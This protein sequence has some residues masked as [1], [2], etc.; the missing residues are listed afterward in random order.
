M[1]DRLWP[2]RI[3]MLLLGVAALIFLQRNPQL[4][5]LFSIWLL[6]VALRFCPA[7]LVRSELVAWGLAA[8]GIASYGVVLDRFGGLAN[9]VVAVSFANVVLTAMHSKRGA[10]RGAEIFAAL[11]GFSYSLYLLHAPMLHFVLTLGR[12]DADPRIGLPPS[13]WHAAV[14]GTGI[15]S[16]I[17]LCAWGMAQITERQT[18]RIR[19]AIIGYSRR[20][21]QDPAVE[22]RPPPRS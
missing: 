12:G 6:G 10:L 16:G 9:L 21:R 11:A 18:G 4:L 15:I 19:A 2:K 7:P 17:T 1:T 5:R 14:I 22:S 20:S 8:I 3:G 13:D